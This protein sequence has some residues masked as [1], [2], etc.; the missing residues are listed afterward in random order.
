MR[1]RTL[2]VVLSGLAVV[3]AAGAVVLWQR[4]PSR[5]TRE[6]F[7]RIKEGMSRA[8]VEAILGPPGDYRTGDGEMD[9]GMENEAW[10]PDTGPDVAKGLSPDFDKLETNWK[11]DPGQSPED[12]SSRADWLGDSFGIAIAIGPSGSVEEKVGLPRRTTQGPLDNLLWRLKRQWRRW[13][14]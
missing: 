11:R 4:P 14:P 7:E 5:I 3:V 12:P 1:K 6:N 2:L 8:E 9:Y 13:F 10:M